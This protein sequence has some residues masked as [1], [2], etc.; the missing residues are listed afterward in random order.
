MYHVRSA[1]VLSI[2]ALCLVIPHQIAE[3]ADK[4]PIEQ[5]PIR[6]TS[7]PEASQL[8]IDYHP[9]STSHLQLDDAIHLPSM[10][11]RTNDNPGR[12]GYRFEGAFE[13]LE[14][15]VRKKL[16]KVMRQFI[17]D[18]PISGSSYEYLE[19]LNRMQQFGDLMADR[20]SQFPQ[21]LDEAMDLNRSAK[22]TVIGEL[23][24]LFVVGPFKL[25]NDLKIDFDSD[26]DI[27]FFD[28]YREES[29][30]EDYDEAVRVRKEDRR[31]TLASFSVAPPRRRGNL[32][33][34]DWVTVD[35]KLAVKLRAKDDYVDSLVS[36]ISLRLKIV[37]Y[38]SYRKPAAEIQM[39]FSAPSSDDLSFTFALIAIEI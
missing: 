23:R 19:Y 33:N 20:T 30:Q 25:T 24:T 5:K 28:A 16:R 26:V 12:Y 36:S 37:I 32:F 10:I 27:D 34:S 22:P 2:L 11:G 18:G 1:S 9:L 35:G 15:E 38:S 17:D 39:R 31:R 3:A 4:K 29:L 6:L 7:E 13:A 14:R 21:S 8:G